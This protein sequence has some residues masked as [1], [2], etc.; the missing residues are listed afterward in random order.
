MVCLALIGRL[1]TTVPLRLNGVDSCQRQLSARSGHPIWLKLG[2]HIGLTRLGRHPLKV[3][4]QI[5]TFAR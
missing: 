1:W 3:D 4:Q 2:T 5:V